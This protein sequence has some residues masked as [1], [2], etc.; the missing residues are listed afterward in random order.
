MAEPLVHRV[1]PDPRERGESPSFLVVVL[2]SGVVL[3]VFFLAAFFVLRETVS[4]LLPG[5]APVRNPHAVLRLPEPP[6]RAV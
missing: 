5:V 4:D 6:V 3:V 1:P 2:I